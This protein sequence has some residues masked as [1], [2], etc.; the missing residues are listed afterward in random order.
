MTQWW[1]EDEAQTSPPRSEHSGTVAS[2][3]SHVVRVKIWQQPGSPN[4]CSEMK[5]FLSTH[6]PNRLPIP[7]S[8]GRGSAQTS[9]SG[10]LRLCVRVLLDAK[11]HFQ[12]AFFW[13]F[14]KFAKGSFC[15][16]V[17]SPSIPP[18]N[19]EN[20]NRPTTWMCFTHSLRL[21]HHTTRCVSCKMRLVNVT[22]SIW[23]IS[24]G[25]PQGCELSPLLFSLYT[26]S[27]PQET[28]LLKPLALSQIMTSPYRREV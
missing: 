28:C 4:S 19:V 26:T 2:H 11:S 5:V 16:N 8:S 7:N 25:A 20:N 23:T 6:L 24:D 15:P 12:L 21:R 17:D 9:H 18:H 13:P 22:S 10:K 3:L 1:N 27:A 14:Q